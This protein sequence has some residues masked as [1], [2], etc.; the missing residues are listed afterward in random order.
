M[1]NRIREVYL[2]VGEVLNKPQAFGLPERI[3][4][5][6][7]AVLAEMQLKLLQ[8]ME[9]AIAE[10]DQL[11]LELSQDADRVKRT[12]ALGKTGS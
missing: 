11:S 8:E 6:L 4:R 7:M 10:Q 9:E 1:N 2:L 12:A 5:P 3:P